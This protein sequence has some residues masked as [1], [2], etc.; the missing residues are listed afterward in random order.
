MAESPLPGV[1]AILVTQGEPAKPPLGP[2]E[3]SSSSNPGAARIS[4]PLS[5]GDIGSKTFI[6][7]WF[8]L[9]G[10]LVFDGAGVLVM[11]Y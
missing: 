2:G 3:D 5:G 7:S 4:S 9:A 8:G 1:K 10:C 6:V 11:L